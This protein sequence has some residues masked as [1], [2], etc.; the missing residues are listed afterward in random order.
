MSPAPVRS[1]VSQP[2]DVADHLIAQVRLD[3][4]F[5]QLA[6]QAV[7]LLFTESSYAC[8]VVNMEFGHELRAGRGS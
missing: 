8:S 5:R 7:Y 2:R 1:H 6:R 4:H 3:R